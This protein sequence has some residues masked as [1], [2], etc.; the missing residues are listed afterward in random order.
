MDL[1][2]SEIFLKM[3]KDELHAW[4][5]GVYG[6]HI[7]P[8]IIHRLKAALRR[9]DLL[10]KAQ[11]S[12]TLGPFFSDADIERVIKRLTKRLEGVKAGLSL[13]TLTPKFSSHVY[14]VY[15]CK[16]ENSKLTGDRVKALMLVLPI[17]LRDI[18]APEVCRPS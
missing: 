12:G 1:I 17:T 7:I 5:L 8:A 14:N 15:H 10:K 2:K 18:I 4:Y 9:P 11:Q 3:P 13:I 16:L 6:E